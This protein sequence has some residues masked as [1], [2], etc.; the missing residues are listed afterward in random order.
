MACRTAPKRVRFTSQCKY[1]ALCGDNNLISIVDP[2]T[3]N[4]KLSFSISEYSDLF[5]CNPER[6]TIAVVMGKKDERK[7]SYYVEIVKFAFCVCLTSF[8]VFD[9]CFTFYFCYFFVLTL[10]VIISM[11]PEASSSGIAAVDEAVKN[12]ELMINYK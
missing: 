6:S 1:V 4:Y 11:K 8:G 12:P 3:D 7:I 10:S 2:D 5:A 9:K